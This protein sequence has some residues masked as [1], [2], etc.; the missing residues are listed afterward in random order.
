MTG[1]MSICEFKNFANLGLALENFE[2]FYNL[3]YF[4]NKVGLMNQAPTEEQ[5]PRVFCP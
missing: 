1:T 5:N 4:S 3:N 2:S